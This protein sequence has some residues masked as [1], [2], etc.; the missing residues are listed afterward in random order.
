METI[1]AE[2]HALSLDLDLVTRLYDRVDQ[3]PTP[4]FASQR[5]RLPCLAFKIRLVSR[6]W[7]GSEFIFHAQAGAL[8]TVEIMTTENFTRQH[9]L[10]LVHP[11][12]DFLLDRRGGG[13]RLEIVPPE[14]ETSEL[15]EFL[16]F[17][18]FPDHSS[19][20]HADPLDD[21]LLPPPTT[22]PQMDVQMEFLARLR[23]PFG[24]LLLASNT[25]NVAEYRRVATENPI[26]VRVQE[27]TSA[28]LNELTQGVRMLDVL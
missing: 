28:T 23:Q 18:S 3:L 16:L 27:I 7:G 2:L 21:E 19:T 4:T 15:D 11:W 17:D 5:M 24:A 13:R 14:N 12:I 10:Y 1:T 26:T 25:W 20:S 8:G 6:R 9:S 22:A